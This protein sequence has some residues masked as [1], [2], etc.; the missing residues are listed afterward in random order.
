MLEDL[1]R[2]SRGIWWTLVI[3]FL[4][5]WVLAKKK[6]RKLFGL[7]AP[8]TNS[9]FYDGLS[10]Y[11]KDVKDTA[12]SWRALDIVYN[13]RF[14]KPKNFSERI[15]NLWHG[16][17][18]AQAVRNRRKIVAEEIGN[19]IERA[20]TQGIKKVKIMSVA[21]GS[22]QSVLEAVGKVPQNV[23]KVLLVD[24]DP[25]AIEHSKNLAQQ[26][27]VAAKFEGVA[28]HFKEYGTHADRFQPHVVE[29]MGLL[30]YLPEPV[31]VAFFREIKKRLPK[32]G[33]LLTC[34]IAPNREQGFLQH[35]IN[36]GNMIYRSK[37][38]LRKILEDAGFANINIFS[39]P[40]GI[41]WIAVCTE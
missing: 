3:N 12:T 21:A 17:D 8:R 26:R 29:V 36:W 2:D 37:E 16:M 22:A 35:V 38:D 24:L 11:C 23:E 6:I 19:A 4:V 27:G 18:N 1:E 40:H 9:M 5:F 10:K 31:A 33:T 28:A 14:E 13:V 30:D 25:A 15:F 20:Q 32:G 41:H 34:N 7:K 39:E